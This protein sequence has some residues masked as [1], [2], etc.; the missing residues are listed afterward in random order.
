MPLARELLSV[1]DIKQSLNDATWKWYSVQ[2]PKGNA[3]H[4]S[5]SKETRKDEGS[6]VVHISELNV[7]KV[8]FTFSVPRFQWLACS[9]VCEI[10]L[11]SAILP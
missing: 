5:S 4:S 9:K 11:V 6:L 8:P 1:A 7:V 3:Y 2:V 10:I